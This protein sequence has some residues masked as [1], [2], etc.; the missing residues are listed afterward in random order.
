MSVEKGKQFMDRSL[1]LFRW[2][3]GH[4]A[5]FPRDCKLRTFGCWLGQE[6]TTRDKECGIEPYYEQQE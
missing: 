6:G 1:V 3:W 2:G 4:R 5:A